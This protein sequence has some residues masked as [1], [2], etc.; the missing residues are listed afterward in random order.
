MSCSRSRKK[1]HSDRQ[2]FFAPAS[3]V[4]TRKLNQE[5]VLTIYD[6]VHEEISQ[7]I[8]GDTGQNEVGD[9]YCCST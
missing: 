1:R 4:L 3:L 8:D 7:P 2:N 6:K 9:A 5:L